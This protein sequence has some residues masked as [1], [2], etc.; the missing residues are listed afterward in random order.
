ME[1][2]VLDLTA[3][4]MILLMVGGFSTLIAWMSFR[5]KR[6]IKRDNSGDVDLLKDELAQLREDAHAQISELHERLDFAERM[7]AQQRDPKLPP[8][9]A[10]PPRRTPRPITPA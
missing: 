3:T 8:L 10:P 6:L 2:W 5:N 4:M 9:P 7:L 1:R